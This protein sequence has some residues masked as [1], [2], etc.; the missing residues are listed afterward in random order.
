MRFTAEWLADWQKVAD[1]PNDGM[2]V[3]FTTFED[4]VLDERQYFKQIFRFYDLPLENLKDLQIEKP[5]PGELHFRSGK[6]NDWRNILTSAQREK[7]T[8]M[9]PASIKE[10]L[11]Y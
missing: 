7:A 1:S 9:I 6:V 8:L 11:G 4:F 5:K 2:D 3:L 10:R